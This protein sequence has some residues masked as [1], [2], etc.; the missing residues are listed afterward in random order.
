[1]PRDSTKERPKPVALF[2]RDEIPPLPGA[3]DAMKIGAYMGH[4]TDSAAPPGLIN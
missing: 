1:M 4:K 3:E 2:H